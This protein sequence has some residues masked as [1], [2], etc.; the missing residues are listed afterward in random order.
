MNS[1]ESPDK[2][3]IQTH[4][5]VKLSEPQLVALGKFAAANESALRLGLP[6]PRYVGPRVRK[7]TSDQS[8]KM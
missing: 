2:A 6:L 5:G 3:H 4:L 8:N 7:K 1:D